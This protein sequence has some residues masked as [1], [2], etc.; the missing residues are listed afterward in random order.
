MEEDKQQNTQNDNESFDWNEYFKTHMKKWG[1][2]VKDLSA[3]T[4][5]IPDI[6]DLQP[7]LYAKRQDAVDYYYTMLIQLSLQKDIYTKARA[8][9]Y[10]RLKTSAQIR[11][12]TE[13]AINA[14]V[15]ANLAGII[16][17]YNMLSNIVSY[18]KDIIKALDGLEFVINRRIDLQKIIDGVK[19]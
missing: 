1:D 6:I 12:T 5:D 7:I 15:D 13:S 16:Y 10:N 9:E 14:Q 2:I 4:K 3:R 19:K 8:A 11:Y 18:M 17:N